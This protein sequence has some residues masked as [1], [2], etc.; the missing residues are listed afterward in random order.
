MGMNTVKLR[1]GKD[2][3]VTITISDKACR[4]YQR[5]VALADQGWYDDMRCDECPLGLEIG[6]TSLCG[7]DSVAELIAMRLE[8]MDEN[9]EITVTELNQCSLK[10]QQNGMEN[11][12]CE[13]ETCGFLEEMG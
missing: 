9:G 4:A 10:I 8:E 5:C 13:I 1:Y 7:I 11:C 12:G 2:A 3:A 6:E